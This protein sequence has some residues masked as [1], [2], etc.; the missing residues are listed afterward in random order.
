M[1]PQEPIIV[2]GTPVVSNSQYRK[3]R[4]LNLRLI[5]IIAAAVIGVVI[6]LIITLAL[7]H[8]GGDFDQ[9]AA[10]IDTTSTGFVPGTVKIKKGQAVT[11]VNKDTLPH[12]IYADQTVTQ[13]LDSVDVLLTGDSY[14]FTFEKAGTYHYYDPQNPSGFQ[15][16]VT[17]E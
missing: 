15:G 6:I 16:T 3:L 14:T 8:R 7:L 12:Q 4:T 10:H 13:S 17:V 11:W 1:P 5:G 2:N 9:A